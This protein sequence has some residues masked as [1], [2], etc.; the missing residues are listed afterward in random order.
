MIEQLAGMIFLIIF[1]VAILAPFWKI[2][3]KAG[4]HPGL[5]ILILVPFVNFLLLYYV[6]FSKWNVC[7]VELTQSEMLQDEVTTGDKL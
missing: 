3:A 2:F 7:H 5:S 1:F 6:A 4:F